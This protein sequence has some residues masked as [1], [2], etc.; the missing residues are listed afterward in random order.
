MLFQL[1]ECEIKEI[2]SKYPVKFREDRVVYK[3]YNEGKF[4]RSFI[5]PTTQFQIKGKNAKVFTKVNTSR[6]TKDDEKIIN[7]IN[8]STCEIGR[9]YTNVKRLYDACI[10]ANI[11]DVKMYVGWLIVT[12]SQAPVHHAYLV[13]KENCV[14]DMTNGI[15]DD[16]IKTLQSLKSI[17]EGREYL[18]NKA[19]ADMEK[20]RVDVLRYADMNSH[21]MYIGAE[22]D[23]MQGLKLFLELEDANPDTKYSETV[24]AMGASKVQ[25]ITLE[26]MGKK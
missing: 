2:E 24:N 6:L 25:A 18:S 4:I 8:S 15:F 19:I 21:C 10:E 9:C 22:L 3:Q 1:P 17:E 11:L 7:V 20:K 23:A 14:I 26:K 5:M 12:E 16:D 13:Y